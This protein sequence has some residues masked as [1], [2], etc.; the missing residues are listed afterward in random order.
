[1]T[2]E[3]SP[4]TEFENKALPPST[5]SL[6][7]VLNA[8]ETSPSTTFTATAH[9]PPPSFSMSEALLMDDSSG[10]EFSSSVD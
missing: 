3:I 7:L 8:C 4:C 10:L 5:P 1:M 2:P 9:L 6:S